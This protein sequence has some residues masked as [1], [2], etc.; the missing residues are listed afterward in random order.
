M[1]AHDHDRPKRPG[2][3][4]SGEVAEPTPAGCLQTPIGEGAEAAP[5]TDT[6][7]ATD[8]PHEPN[9][10]LH[11]TWTDCPG[12]RVEDDSFRPKSCA[13]TEPHPHHDRCPGI[14]DWHAG[15]PGCAALRHDPTFG[16][17]TWMVRLCEHF[18]A[19]H[20]VVL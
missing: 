4:L 5:A 8:H 15:C 7:P 16:Y 12:I 18:E 11:G 10:W 14:P 6:C 1:K 13:S 19:A 20:G 17:M 9:Q 3:P 2:A